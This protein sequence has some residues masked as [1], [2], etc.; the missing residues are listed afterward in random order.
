MTTTPQTEAGT[1]AA[2]TKAVTLQLSELVLKTARYDDM[3]V[4]YSEL[5]R[6]HNR[7]VAL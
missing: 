4:I 5:L 7:A 1:G 2:G 3:A 6:L